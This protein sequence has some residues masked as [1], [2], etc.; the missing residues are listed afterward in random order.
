V[1]RAHRPEDALLYDLAAEWVGR[2]LL[3]DGS[4]FDDSRERL[5][6]LANF[7][8]L[9][10]VF[11]E[12]PDES[13]DPFLVKLSRQL[14]GAS[15]DLVLLFAELLYIHLFAAN[16]I[17]GAAKR[18]NVTAVLAQMTDG[19]DLPLRFDE[20]LE[21]GLVSTGVAYKTYR[22]QQLWLFIDVVIAL[23]SLS[24]QERR[25]TLED[26][27][28]F[29]DLVHR[30]PQEAAF[31][32]RNVLLH[33]VHPEA[34]EDCVLRDYKQQIAAA[35]AH[36]TSADDD[37]DRA[38]LEVRGSLEAEAGEPINFYDEPYRSQW[39]RER[40]HAWEMLEEVAPVVTGWEKYDA[41]ERRYKLELAERLRDLYDGDR[42]EG[43]SVDALRAIGRTN[44]V[45]FR[46]LGRLRSWGSEHPAQLDA[47][48]ATLAD[49]EAPLDALDRFGE[50]IGEV[51]PTRGARLSVGAVLMM[52]LDPTAYAPWR[53]EAT[54][55]YRRLLGIE[56]PTDEADSEHYRSYLEMLDLV[57]DELGR[58]AIRL[59]DRLDTQSLLFVVASTDLDDEPL[60]SLSRRARRKFAAW[61]GDRG[62]DEVDE[63]DDD[64]SR[65]ERWRADR[66]R[67]ITDAAAELDAH[68]S[69]AV[70]PSIDDRKA[71]A[72]AALDRLRDDGDLQAFVTAYRESGDALRHTRKGAHQTFL[73]ALANRADDE[74]EAAQVVAEALM[75][76]ASEDEIGDHLEPLIE[77]AR[78][79]GTPHAPTQG[80]A[81]LVA[82]AFWN[83]QDPR[84]LPLFRSAE[85][86]LSWWGWLPSSSTGA[87]RYRAYLDVLRSA[88]TAGAFSRVGNGWFPGLDPSLVERLAANREEV[89]DDDAG[90]SRRRNLEHVR[91]DLKV[92]DRC[93]VDS[94]TRQL[95]QPLETVSSSL[96]GRSESDAFIAWRPRSS[97]T[98]PPPDVRLWVT[99]DGVA[100][101][102]HPGGGRDHLADSLRLAE[103]RRPDDV[104]LLAVSVDQHGKRTFTPTDQL[105]PGKDFLVGRWY[106]EASALGRGDLLDDLAALVSRLKPL[107]GAWLAHLGSVSIPIVDREDDE[108]LA[109]QVKRFLEERGYPSLKDRQRIETRAELRSVLTREG[110]DT[111]DLDGLR[112]VINSNVGGNPGPQSVLNST[113]RDASPQDLDRFFDA[114]RYLL[115]DG[116][117]SEAVRID[118]LLDKGDLGMP[119]LGESV[120]VKLLATAHPERWVPVF[121]LRGDMG[122]VRLMEAL[123]LPHELI[124]TTGEQHV[125]ANAAI[126]QRLEPY[127]PGDTWG[128]KDFAY[129][130]A[131]QE[132]VEDATGDVDLVEKAATELHVS[133]EF[134]R[135]VVELLREKK[136]IILY[137][138]PG[139]GKTYLA[140]RLARALVN[141]D[142]A[143]YRLVQ[144]HPSYS[145]EDFFE[146]YRPDV[147][148]DGQLTYQLQQGPFAQIVEAAEASPAA[149]HVMIIDEIN[150]ANL[151][152][153]FGELLFLLEY[154]DEPAYTQYRPTEP[155]TV[156][157][158]L[159]LIGTM[160]TADRS[161]ALVDAALRRRFHFVG[162][163]PHEGE[164]AGLLRRWLEAEGGPTWVADLLDQVNDELRR[165]LG[166]P[167]LQIGPSYFMVDGLDETKLE[168]IW[169][170][171]IHPYIEEQL[172]GQQDRIDTYRFDAV[173]A[174]FQADR[175]TIA[176]EDDEEP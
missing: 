22:P 17:G 169:R 78:R 171:S 20:R 104:E 159:Y 84:W 10:E 97:V 1:A 61:R 59:R 30:V 77:L 127:F 162:F 53:A 24:P 15:D 149:E 56:G 3:D 67:Q 42:P 170:Y 52:G 62:F 157:K 18:D 6:S 118:R 135:E 173:W 63:P 4:L 125:A 148:A 113:L 130:L 139:T 137:G 13:S 136:Q 40:L 124:G 83:L 131:S 36:L 115:W 19:V 9:R 16:D 58:R 45:N 69:S 116:D 29:K 145:Y 88:E 38:L 103:G 95:G 158:K 34:F 123:D 32:Q 176:G 146:G 99:P 121:P 70:T 129:W 154:R 12:Q 39:A 65:E 126:R 90:S 7:K 150:R 57:H 35:Y 25:T 163:F 166:G 153:V 5:W 60:A 87:E 48:V 165:D 86:A 105:A 164:V 152:K 147:D 76:P 54:A 175:T 11:N 68:G 72:L 64:G 151:P 8:R 43:W 156:P 140:R 44:L 94:L 117:E 144:F 155:F 112:K 73:G 134:L 71:Y 27:W 23:K 85:N 50:M 81:P 55:T 143:R 31:T 111:Y 167:H 161:I 132:D 128:M 33:L 66:F 93:F 108:A 142:E 92:L 74:E 21:R 89:D 133:V 120:I 96:E 174:R 168:R 46:P 51:L 138:P 41:E 37:V 172:F 119:G 109:L 79:T 2:C 160:N 75:A 114:I 49:S 26:P 122:K 101:G 28:R 141:E 102:V 100:V 91:A 107:L 82:S 106:P 110:L 47:A 14:A 80:M 98:S